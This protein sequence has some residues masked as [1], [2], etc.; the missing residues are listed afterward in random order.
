[1]WDLERYMHQAFSHRR[2][3]WE[4]FRLEPDDV[5]LFCAAVA[6]DSIDDL[7]SRLV[8]QR[9]LNEANGFI[10]GEEDY[11]ACVP[12]SMKSPRKAFHI[13]DE[14][15]D[16]LQEYLKSCD[17][18]PR[19]SAVMRAALRDFLTRKGHWPPKE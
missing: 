7:P 5:A 12:S 6:V 14:L 4:W 16:A 10:W 8:A 3:K 18:M 2:V 13:S 19:E 1:M 11:S 15:N 9:V 17:V